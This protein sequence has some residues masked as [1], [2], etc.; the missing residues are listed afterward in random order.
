MMRH[1]T[2]ASPQ[3]GGATL[4]T[5]VT[6][7]E[8]W[9]LLTLVCLRLLVASR[10]ALG[11]DELAYW[12]WAWHGLD[13][14]Y[15]LV[16]V[17]ALR[18]STF[19]FG[20]GSLG[21]RLP[22]ALAAIGATLLVIRLAI[23][24]GATPRA[25]RWAG[26]AFAAAPW[27]NYVGTIAHPDAFLCLF[28]LLFADR[29]AALLGAEDC[30]KTRPL[31]AAAVA[32]GLVALTKLTGAILLPVAAVVAWRHRRESP[33]AAVGALA[34]LAATG[35]LLIVSRDQHILSGLREFGRFAEAT[36]P[37]RRFAITAL[38]TAVFGGPAL[39]YL[40]ALG[41][42]RSIRSAASATVAVAGI[43]GLILALHATFGFFGQAKGNWF[44]APLALLVP[45]GAASLSRRLRPL[46]MAATTSIVL[47]IAAGVFCLRPDV[48][49]ESSA[50]SS[51][52]ILTALDDSYADHLGERE[53][54]VSST[55]R[56]SDRFAEFRS[57]ELDLPRPD[58]T[59]PPPRV[60]SNDY[61]LAFAIVHGWGRDAEAFLPW[62]P[63]FTRSC[64]RSP[65]LGESV[66]FVSRSRNE[67]PSEYS[68]GFAEIRAM[69]ISGAAND[70]S[71]SVL[72]YCREWLLDSDPAR[73]R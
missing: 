44:L 55:R 52:R 66:I 16:T 9:I 53:V 13:A 6:A 34:V 20:D 59:G 27:Q 62:D 70:S 43:A 69:P 33:R 18:I 58:G 40:A 29:M 25:A 49:R 45:A 12:Y 73:P 61:G 23:R 38:E 36:S 67:L 5:L 8:S 15:S 7:G 19:L 32:A 3:R 41:G 60:C 54:G 4:R 42:A 17:G 68:R 14:S 57:C 56:W 28:L 48:L 71:L 11:R 26:V 22:G 51:N 63:V 30:R 31:L 72:L 35:T 46:V 37:S 50:L 47:S 24:L 65:D 2:A 39:L 21:L 1:L 64:G 10:L